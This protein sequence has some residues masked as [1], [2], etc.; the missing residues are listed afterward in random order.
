MNDLPRVAA[1]QC[2][3]WELNPQSVDCK[4]SALATTL[5]SHIDHVLP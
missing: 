2:F 5:P 4:S 3:G 1:Q